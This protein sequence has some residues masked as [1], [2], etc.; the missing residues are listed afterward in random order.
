MGQLSHCPLQFSRPFHH[1]HL[2]FVAGF[3]SFLLSA[4]PF[5]NQIRAAVGCRRMIHSHCE[6]HPV[7]FGWEVAT[8]TADGYKTSVRVEPNRNSN[9]AER[10]PSVIKANN[11][12]NDLPLQRPIESIKL[13]LQPIQEFPGGA[14]TRD[15]DRC[16]SGGIEQAYERKIK[17]QRPRQDVGQSGGNRARCHPT[18]PSRDCRKCD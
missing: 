6:Q 12:W 1:L 8:L 2:E 13:G 15:V 9:T 3:A 18:P 11:I 16:P 14:S 10:F 17:T 7:S 5:M 4:A